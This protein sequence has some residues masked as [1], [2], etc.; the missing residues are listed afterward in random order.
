VVV[1]VLYYVV[2]HP[3]LVTHKDSSIFVLGK[4]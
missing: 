3:F 4:Y 2:V 1:F